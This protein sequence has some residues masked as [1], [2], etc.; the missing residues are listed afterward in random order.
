MTVQTILRLPRV[1]AALGVSTATVYRW[2]ACGLWPSPV[3]IGMTAVGWLED[4]VNA[5]MQARIAGETDDGV[6]ALIVKLQA[7]RAGGGKA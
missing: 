2:I 3:R 6:R 7:A 5:V 1:K 4:E